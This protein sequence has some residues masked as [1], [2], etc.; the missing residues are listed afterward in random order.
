[1]PLLAGG[2]GVP[3]ATVARR[4]GGDGWAADADQLDALLSDM[5]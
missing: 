5:R 3:D 2:P 4:L 1:V